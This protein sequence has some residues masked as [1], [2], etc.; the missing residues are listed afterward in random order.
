MLIAIIGFG[1]LTFI[2]TIVLITTAKAVN[3]LIEHE[4]ARM[5]QDAKNWHSKNVTY[6]DTFLA[7]NEL[8]S[9]DSNLI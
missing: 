4:N 6:R 8:S 5:D 3:R 7:N 2:N 9:N 1:I